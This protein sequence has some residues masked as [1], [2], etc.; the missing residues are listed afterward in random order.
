MGA[1]MLIATLVIDEACYPDFA[2]AH[3]AIEVVTA[4]DI[5]DEDEFCDMPDPQTGSGLSA[6]R[7]DLHRCLN[8]LELALSG[9]EFT[10]DSV[11][12]ATIY[13]TGGLSWGDSPSE[14]FEIVNRL[15]AV[16]GVL[17]AAG[18]EDEL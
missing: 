3:R 15:R 16:R 10:A 5:E 12:G 4:A 8:E 11:R 7:V 2:A 9:R 17:R 6:L 13:I 14:A 18:F 1:D